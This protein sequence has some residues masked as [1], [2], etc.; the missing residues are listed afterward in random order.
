[1]VVVDDVERVGEHDAEAAVGLRRRDSLALKEGPVGHIVERDGGIQQP[2]DGFRVRGVAEVVGLIGDDETPVGQCGGL[3][4]GL[5][6]GDSVPAAGVDI[7]LKLRSVRAQSRGHEGSVL[8]WRC[9]G[10]GSCCL[11]QRPLACLTGTFGF[12]GV[13]VEFLLRVCF[14][15]EHHPTILFRA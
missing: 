14:P 12:R 3:G 9:N 8:F 10:C 4:T 5:T 2:V 15:S 1:M 6:A 11:L 13:F 7:D